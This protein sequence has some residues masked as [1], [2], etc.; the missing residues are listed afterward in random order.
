MRTARWKYAVRAP[1]LRGTEQPGNDEYEEVEL[2]D[3]REDP[4]ELDNLITSRAHAPVRAR[5]R[6]RLLARIAAVEKSTPRILE[7]EAVGLGQRQIPPGDEN[8]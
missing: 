6:Q 1:G 7:V 8:E 2:Y 3:L 5:M 4:W